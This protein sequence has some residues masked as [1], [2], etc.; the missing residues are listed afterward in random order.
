AV[1]PQT[2]KPGPG[3]GF[4]LPFYSGQNIN[5]PTTAQLLM[6]VD[7]DVGNDSIRSAQNSGDAQVDF[8]V[9]GLLPTDLL[10]FNVYAWTF[11]AQVADSSINWTNNLSTNLVTPGQSGF[12]LTDVPE[13][14]SL[15]LL[16]AALIG[17]MALR[18][19]KVA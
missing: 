13:P 8:D 10:S 1:G 5:D 7:L 16:A 15:S 2:A 4:V 18:S 6:F 3:N 17:L 14:G 9:S 19:R 11:S 12:S